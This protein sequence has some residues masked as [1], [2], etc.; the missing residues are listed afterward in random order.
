ML[1]LIGVIVA[2]ITMIILI[3]KKI[4]KKQT[5]LIVFLLAVLALTFL[6]A[7]D[8]EIAERL[9]TAKSIKSRTTLQTRKHVWGGSIEMIKDNPLVGT[10]V[11]TFLW[12]FPAYQPKELAGRPHYAYNVYLQM[13]A[14]M[15]IL[16]LPLILWMM[17]MVIT[18]GC[19]MD[20]IM[21][22]AGIGILSLALHGLVDFN[23]HIPANML[24]VSCLAGI[25][26]RKNAE[27][28]R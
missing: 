11:G 25:I 1:N 26:M 2:F 13:M 3:R 21:L 12:G 9:H 7:G 8:D 6:S 10:G 28:T 23:F 5:A 24:V 14:E 22:G 18:A 4:L 17:V 16:A 19:K 15:G 27:R 20:G